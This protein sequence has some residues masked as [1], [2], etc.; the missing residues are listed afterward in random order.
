[1]AFRDRGRPPGFPPRRVRTRPRGMASERDDAGR[2]RLRRSGRRRHPRPRVP[3]L[4]RVRS[5]EGAGC[6]G[7]CL[8]TSLGTNRRWCSMN[9]C[10]DRV[11]KARLAE[12]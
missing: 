12:S 3:D 9:T 4:S 6:A 11:E 8:D 1:M 10:G 2:R 7:L 5:R